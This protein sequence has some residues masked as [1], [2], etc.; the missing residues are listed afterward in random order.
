MADLNNLLLYAM[1]TQGSKSPD[2][3]GGAPPMDMKKLLALS[4]MGGGMGGGMGGTPA[5]AAPGQSNPVGDALS[6]IQNAYQQRK[7]IEAIT[8]Q[9]QSSP[10]DSIMGMMGGGGGKGGGALSGPTGM[11]GGASAGIGGGFY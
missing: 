11:E 1:L 5:S 9:K 8:G 4:M 2:A 10:L 7:M 6:G 3:S